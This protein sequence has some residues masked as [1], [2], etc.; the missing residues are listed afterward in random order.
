MVTNR[1]MRLPMLAAL[2]LYCVVCHEAWGRDNVES[3]GDVLRFVLPAAAA[4]LT[5][6]F[7]DNEGLFQFGKAMAVT[8]GATYGLKYAINEERPDGGDR[9]FPSGHTSVS[10]ASAEFLRKRYGWPYGIPAYAAAAFVGYS[11]VE[12]DKHYTHDV[13]AGAAL[14]V[15]SSFLFTTPYQGWDFRIEA[16]SGYCGIGLCHK[17]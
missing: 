15:V 5:L 1:D 3:T 10:F 14:G 12:A 4:G 16:D 7:E 13:I 6:R 11:R 8:L 2:L 9:S 17:W